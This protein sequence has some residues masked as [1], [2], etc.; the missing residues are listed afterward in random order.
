LISADAC[1][2]LAYCYMLQTYIS[3]GGGFKALIRQF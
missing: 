2:I 1:T 3:R